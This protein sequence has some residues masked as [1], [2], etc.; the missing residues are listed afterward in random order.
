VVEHEDPDQ[1]RVDATDAA[2]YRDVA[3][4]LPDQ[5]RQHEDSEGGHKYEGPERRA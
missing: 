5:V 1:A 2:G 4:P 3:A